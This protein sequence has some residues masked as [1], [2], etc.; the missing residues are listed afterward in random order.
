MGSWV[1]KY[2]RATIEDGCCGRC[3]FFW[4][5]YEATFFTRTTSANPQNKR[6]LDG[7]GNPIVKHRADLYLS[8][9]RVAWC[10]VLGGL[11]SILY[12]HHGLGVIWQKV[13]FLRC[14][15][16]CCSIYLKYL[17][18]GNIGKFTSAPGPS[19]W[20]RPHGSR[21]WW[22]WSCHSQKQAVHIPGLCQSSLD[23]PRSAA[24]CSLPPLCNPMRCP[25]PSFYVH[26]AQLK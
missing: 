5:F 12:N 24:V 26:E 21:R 15:W 8:G 23:H 1:K 19:I 11:C 16:I 6:N 4:V 17:K 2:S 14:P 13:L 10:L 3:C 7:I 22:H 18:Y 9:R 20:Y 25:P